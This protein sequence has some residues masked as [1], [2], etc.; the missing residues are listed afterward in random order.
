MSFLNT[1]TGFRGLSGE[2]LGVRVSRMWR[3]RVKARE[4][5]SIGMGDAL[6][7][8]YPLEGLNV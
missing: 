4:R 6:W 3:G 8:E 7:A 1:H 2:D 5:H